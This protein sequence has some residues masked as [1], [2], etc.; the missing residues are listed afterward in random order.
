MEYKFIDLD[1]LNTNCGDDVSM[2]KELL[3]MG[4][5]TISSS[6][7]QIKELLDKQD[8]QNLA[9]TLHKLRPVLSYCGVINYLID[10]E[11]MEQEILTNKYCD[12]DGFIRELQIYLEDTI[13]EINNLLG[14]L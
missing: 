10:M 5:E 12:P 1:R 14:E 2:K 9:R 3:N 6:N 13:L 4:L 7:Q 11:K 8:W